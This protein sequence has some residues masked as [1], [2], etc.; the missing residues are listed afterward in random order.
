MVEKEAEGKGRG[1]FTVNNLSL[2]R[3]GESGVRKFGK[4]ME[5]KS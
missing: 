2:E 1:E 3:G 4:S 5:K